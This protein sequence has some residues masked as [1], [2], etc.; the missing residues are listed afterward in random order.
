MGRPRPGLEPSTST[1]AASTRLMSARASSHV[2]ITEPLAARR[3]ERRFSG[4]WIAVGAHVPR[5]AGLPV[6]HARKSRSLPMVESIG[7]Q[8]LTMTLRYMPLSPAALDAAIR[9]LDAPAR[10][11]IRGEIVETVRGSA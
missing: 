3:L 7:Q 5:A 6:R 8:D 11:Q 10:G 4:E 2:R 1:T 9:L